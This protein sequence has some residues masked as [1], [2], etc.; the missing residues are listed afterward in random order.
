MKLYE[1]AQDSGRD[2]EKQL[3]ESK[4]MIERLK[5]DI[6]KADTASEAYLTQ[7]LYLK[8]RIVGLEKIVKDINSVEAV[9]TAN[10]LRMQSLY[11][12][13]IEEDNS[14]SESAKPKVTNSSSEEKKIDDV[15]SKEDEVES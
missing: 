1:S 4:V 5:K 11:Y 12:S 15:L 13:T 14:D 2:K 8:E 6:V 7:M 10:E 3:I 9:P